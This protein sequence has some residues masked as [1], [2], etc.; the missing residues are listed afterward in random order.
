VAGGDFEPEDFAEDDLDE[1][2]FEEDLDAMDNSP[3][4]HAIN[5]SI[6]ESFRLTAG[7]ARMRQ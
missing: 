2:D 1:D 4:C 5:G 7:T 3:V 6:R